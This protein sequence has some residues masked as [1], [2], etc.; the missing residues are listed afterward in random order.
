MI[1]VTMYPF[2]IIAC[3]NYL[4][5]SS[6]LA[7]RTEHQPP[8]FSHQC[9]MA[10]PCRNSPSMTFPELIGDG[11]CFTSIQAHF[12]DTRWKKHIR[13]KRGSVRFH[14]MCGNIKEAGMYAWRRDM[15]A[16]AS[17]EAS[18]ESDS[19]KKPDISLRFEKDLRLSDF[20]TW[21]IGGPADFLIRVTTEEEMA[22]A[23][24]Y[25][26]HSHIGRLLPNVT[27]FILVAD[28]GKMTKI[29]QQVPSLI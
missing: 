3:L 17:A 24:R 6:R 2:D 1:L 28:T 20:S 21:G 26:M 22:D 5:F 27:L 13:I 12:L 25:R 29:D 23:F 10:I 14:A 15:P 9:K 16:A 7:F 11:L 4:C 8:L 19:N 18:P